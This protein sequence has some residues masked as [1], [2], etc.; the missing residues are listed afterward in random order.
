ML[1]ALTSLQ[2]LCLEGALGVASLP[3]I[4]G[5]WSDRICREAFI[6]AALFLMMASS[7]ESFSTPEGSSSVLSWMT[8]RCGLDRHDHDDDNN[9]NIHLQHLLRHPSRSETIHYHHHNDKGA[10]HPLL[11]PTLPP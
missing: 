8:H 7:S 1:T 4:P 6:T 11:K 2:Y 5:G 9:K 3:G 10:V